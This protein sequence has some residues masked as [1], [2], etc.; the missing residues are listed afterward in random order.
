MGELETRGCTK[1]GA[2][3]DWYADRGVRGDSTGPVND[4][5]SPDPRGGNRKPPTTSF[6]HNARVAGCCSAVCLPFSMKET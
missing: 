5:A 4:G 3:W 2:S 6:Q 1:R